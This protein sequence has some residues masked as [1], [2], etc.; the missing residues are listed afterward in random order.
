MIL[1]DPAKPDRSRHVEYRHTDTLARKVRGRP[2]ALRR[3]DEY[4][5]EAKMPRRKH[6]HGDILPVGAL[7]RSQIGSYRKFAAIEGV[8]GELLVEQRLH[9]HQ[10][11]LGLRA[12]DRYL[13]ARDGA[14]PVGIA[15]P[16]FQW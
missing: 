1:E 12:R 9:A 4:T 16:D 3:V 2:D 13:A 15:N 10:R 8:F 6:W 14:G 5:R 11:H 7:H